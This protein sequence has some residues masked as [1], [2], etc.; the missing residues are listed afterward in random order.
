MKPKMSRRD[1]LIGGMAAAVC[2]QYAPPAYAVIPRPSTRVDFEVPSGACDCHFHIFGDPERFPFS[3]GRTYTPQMA[4]VHASIAFHKALHLERLVVVNSLVY[5]ADN[6]CMLDALQQFGRRSRGVALIEDATPET[7]LDEMARAGVCGI[8]LNFVNAGISDAAI[9][10][11]RFL[12]AVRRVHKRNWHIQIYTNLAG[13]V[14]LAKEVS[15]A[16]VAVVFDHFA[17]AKASLGVG[18]AGFDTLVDLVRSGKAYVKLSAAYRV[19]R[20]SP[21]YLDVAPLA[22]ALV[23]TNPERVLWGTDWPHPDTSRVAGRKAT[24]IAPF[25]QIDDALLFNQLPIWAPTAELRRMILVENPARL[26]GF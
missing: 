8:R 5:G 1:A 23:G 13:V 19:S 2:S 18:Q 11:E 20:K 24:D 15:N 7:D 4:S 26:Y 21:D 16:P 6:S 17:D 25:L 10:R 22:R 14:A 9:L 12:A 3:A